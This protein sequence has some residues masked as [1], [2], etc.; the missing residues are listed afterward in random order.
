MS[1]QN[2]PQEQS[3]EGLAPYPQQV[4]SSDSGQFVANSTEGQPL[5]AEG[6]SPEMPN[7]NQDFGVQQPIFDAPQQDNWGNPVFQ[8]AIPQGFNPA[9][10]NF[11]GSQQAANF[12]GQ[13]SPEP[14][15][16]S[17][18][19]LIGFLGIGL[20]AGLLLGGLGGYFLNDFMSGGSVPSLSRKGHQSDVASFVAP[21]KED[22]YEWEV[23]D[24]EKLSIVSA[25]DEGLTPEQVVKDFGLASSVTFQEEGLSL[26]WL[27]DSSYTTLTFMKHEDG[28]YHLQGMSIMPGSD[29]YNKKV[30][31]QITESLKTGDAETGEGG[32]S[33][34]EVIKEYPEYQHIS[35]YGDGESEPKMLVNYETSSNK[36]ITLTFIRQENGQ[37]LLSNLSK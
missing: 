17:T 34:K 20:A 21:S 37:Y 14:K 9:G 26:S 24:L 3:L 2:K 12:A 23:K 1:E 15:K 6:G 10:Q 32:S 25:D 5:P 8:E 7:P 19:K 13:P 16:N 30:S 27:P 11:A 35:V 18:G 22:V 28:S 31:S 4:Q 36:E 29:S 33:F